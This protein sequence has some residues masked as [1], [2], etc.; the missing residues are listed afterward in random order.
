MGAA[1]IRAM[2]S[3]LVV[4][5]I[6]IHF[7][8][9][10]V[11]VS[12]RPRPRPQQSANSSMPLCID[13]A[14]DIKKITDHMSANRKKKTKYLRYKEALGS[15][16]DLQ[17]FARL[18]YAE[19]LAANCPD[20]KGQVVSRITDVVG[21]RIMKRNQDVKSVV[22][23]RDQFSS[24][25]NKYSSSKYK[26]FLCPKDVGLWNTAYQNAQKFL[27]Q[28][29]GTLSSDTINYFL[30]KHDPRWTEAPAWGLKENAE[31]SNPQL[32]ACIRVFKNPKW[33]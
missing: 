28:G 8:L 21:N 13:G 19:T 11:T 27:E 14:T 5:F 32:R 1:K 16:S 23:Q 10:E 24:S 12:P 9:A 17:L 20:M 30:Y 29:K 18:V 31:G 6:L 22:F 26:E 15:D 4:F 25:L 33:R 3:I 7:S 2:N